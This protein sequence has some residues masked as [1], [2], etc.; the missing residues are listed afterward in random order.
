M[1]E[2]SQYRPARRPMPWSKAFSKM[3]GVV[4]VVMVSTKGAPSTV[5]GQVELTTAT[6]LYVQVSD[7]VGLATTQGD[8]IARTGMLYIRKVV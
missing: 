7:S 6:D 3:R 2:A 5:V 4:V 1:A 8:T